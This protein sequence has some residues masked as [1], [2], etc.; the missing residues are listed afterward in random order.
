[1]KESISKQSSSTGRQ[2][3]EMQKNKQ[4]LK[5]ATKAPSALGSIGSVFGFGAEIEAV[6]KEKDQMEIVY[7]ESILKNMELQNQLKILG[8]DI[9]RLTRENKQLKKQA[10]VQNE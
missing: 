1:M 2:T 5:S 7:T 8:D 6:E 10:P 9:E 3:P 4:M